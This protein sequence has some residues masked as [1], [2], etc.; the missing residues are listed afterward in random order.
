WIR[1]VLVLF[2][3]LGG[4]GVLAYIILWIVM[5]IAETRADKM[6]MR[7]EEPNLQNFK[8][9]FDEEAKN[10]SETFSTT[11]ERHE[12]GARTAAGNL[13]SGCLGLIGKMIAWIML[14]FAGLN[15][16]SLFIF[17]MFNMMNFF[18][19]ENPMFFPPLKG[20]ATNDGIIALTFG[21]LAI[22]IPFFALF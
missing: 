6:A 14:I 7:G 20:L 18:G 1:V 2:F 4:S 13:V 9:S 15:L 21:F 19:L 11:G 8:K 17:Y 5:P 22:A 3:L 10:V 12:R 16:L